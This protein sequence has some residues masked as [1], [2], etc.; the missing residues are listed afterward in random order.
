[1]AGQRREHLWTANQRVALVGISA[2]LLVTIVV[3]YV[4]NP[5]FVGNP[6]S[7]EPPRAAELADRIDPNTADLTTLSA[8][9]LL[10]EK[11]AKLIIDYREHYHTLKPDEL[12]YQKPEDLMR[13]RGIG[14]NM[15]DQLRPFLI[16]PTTQP[17]TQP[18]APPTSRQTSAP[19]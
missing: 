10:G 16:F 12:V 6:Q 4:R 14:V 18:T 8:L 17:G 11:R 1:M 3:L 19:N 7:D 2:A 9:P 15:V 5:S 13:V